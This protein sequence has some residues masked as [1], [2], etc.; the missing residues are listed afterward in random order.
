MRC[1]SVY[2]LRDETDEIKTISEKTGDLQICPECI[3]EDVD[4]LFDGFGLEVEDE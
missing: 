1:G 2:E 3:S 4:E